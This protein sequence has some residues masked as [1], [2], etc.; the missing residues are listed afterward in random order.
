MYKTQVGGGHGSA[1]DFGA[2]PLVLVGGGDARVDPE[3]VG[4]VPGC[5]CDNVSIG[6][7]VVNMIFCV[8]VGLGG[9]RY[10]TRTPKVNPGRL[11]FF[12]NGLLMIQEGGKRNKVVCMGNKPQ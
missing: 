2:L 9:S 1:G 11:R 4:C 8:G 6:W 7:I 12:M 10:H 3:A 5:G